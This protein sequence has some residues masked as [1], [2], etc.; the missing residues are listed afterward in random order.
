MSI[1]VLIIGHIL[2]IPQPFKRLNFFLTHPVCIFQRWKLLAYYCHLS[3]CNPNID[4]LI[5]ITEFPVTERPLEMY[6]TIYCEQTNVMY[7]PLPLGWA[8]S[9]ETQPVSSLPP[10]ITEDKSH[11]SYMPSFW[12]INDLGLKNLSV[13]NDDELG[14]SISILRFKGLQI[15]FYTHLT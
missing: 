15:P 9:E 2:F 10:G 4:G 8:T 14:I 6:S 12:P 1:S 13:T 5:V 11:S 3:T 7:F